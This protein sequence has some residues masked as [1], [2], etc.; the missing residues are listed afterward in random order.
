ML[1]FDSDVIVRAADMCNTEHEECLDLNSVATLSK[2]KTIYGT[3][4]RSWVES[5]KFL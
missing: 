2:E 5:L 1:H 3:E 4:G